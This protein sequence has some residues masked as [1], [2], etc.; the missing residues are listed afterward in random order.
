M[1][2]K[3]FLLERLVKYYLILPCVIYILMIVAFPLIYSLGLS[4]FEWNPI[5][6][7]FSPEFIAFR[8]FI[9][10]FQD[11]RFWK[12]ILNTFIFVGGGIVLQFTIGLGL[13]I[14]MNQEIKGQTV[15]RI[16]FLLP[17]MAAPVVVGY[18]FRML[19]HVTNGPLNHLLGLMGF[20]TSLWYS[21]GRTAMVSMILIDTWQW[22]PFIFLIALAG[23]HSLPREPLEAAQIDGASTPQIFR[24]ITLPLLSP[25]LIISII[26][27]VVESIK[28][29][30]IIFITTRG[31]PGM[32]T[33]TA[34][35]YIR[36]IGFNQFRLGYASAM[37]YIFLLFAIGVFIFLTTFF[38]RERE[39]V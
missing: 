21:S 7:G 18:M 14:L 20:P 26:L 12:V 11:M 10:V 32:A 33:E 25:V 3:R 8:N 4:F 1:F 19:F 16:I 6:P 30:D 39:F 35:V 34:T 31:G 15:F 9:E 5:I 24:Y 38:R 23:L 2:R 13:A 17:M 27:R 29:F 37:S 28:I 36:N 22:T